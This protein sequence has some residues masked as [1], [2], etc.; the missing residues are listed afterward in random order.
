M[1]KP[2]NK[3]SSLHQHQWCP[4]WLLCGKSIDIM[5]S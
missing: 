4:C 5:F 1:W 3:T 2:Q